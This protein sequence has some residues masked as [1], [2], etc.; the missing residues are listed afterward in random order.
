[1][2][3]KA[4][5]MMIPAVLLLS[6]LAFSFC[7]KERPD[8]N[9]PK[10]PSRELT[11]Q[12]KNKLVISVLPV[13][14]KDAAKTDAFTEHFFGDKNNAGSLSAD[15]DYAVRQAVIDGLLQNKNKSKYTVVDTR[16]IEKLADQHLFEAGPWSD[17]NKNAQIDKELNA[18]VIALLDAQAGPTSSVLIISVT[19]MNVNTMEV[20]AKAQAEVSVRNGAFDA[21]K[22]LASVKNMK[23]NF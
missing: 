3:F 22:L 9:T 6:S 15:A 21:G 16:H 10:N 19:L 14:V 5:V 20:N 13:G 18:N 23:I 1:M 7:A 17:S 4:R 12:S 2:F 8:S 11:E